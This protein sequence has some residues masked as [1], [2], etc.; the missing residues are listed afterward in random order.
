MPRFFC[1]A[2]LR[3]E[4]EG[5]PPSQPTQYPRVLTPAPAGGL[6]LRARAPAAAQRC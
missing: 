1:C 4:R 5:D 6:S 2:R 3:C